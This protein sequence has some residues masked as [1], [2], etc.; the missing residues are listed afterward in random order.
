MLKI[1][2]ALVIVLLVAAVIVL[3]IKL[4]KTD[5]NE[6]VP[7]GTNPNTEPTVVLTG[8]SE[9]VV[10]ETDE[11][12][13]EVEEVG[14]YLPDVED[15][16]E[17]RTEVIEDGAKQF[18]TSGIVRILTGEMEGAELEINEGESFVIGRD[19]EKCNIIFDDPNISRVHCII[20][21]DFDFSCGAMFYVLDKSST[22]TFIQN[23]SASG[24]VST[25]RLNPNDEVRAQVNDIVLLGEKGEQVQL[26]Y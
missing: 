5:Q 11:K 23:E 15:P 8:N 7:V 14:D 18:R 19:P 9:T 17:R 22:G 3:L 21:Y 1:G 6:N 10:L 16:G 12:A 2:I 13:T 4:K 26:V 20:R 25:H 24:K